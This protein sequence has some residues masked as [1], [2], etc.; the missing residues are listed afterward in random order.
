[1]ST[2]LSAALLAARLAAAAPPAGAAPSDARIRE[3]I[4]TYL[5][6]IDRPIPASR[7][8]A[9]GPAAA[10]VL[11]SIA[12]SPGEMPSDRAKAIEAL[13]V[14]DGPRAAALA[15]TLAEAPATPFSVRVSAVRSLGE[16]TPPG[17]LRG[18]LHPV[19]QNPDAR[20]RAVAAEALARRGGADGCAAVRAQVAGEPERDRGR[21]H[22]AVSLCEGK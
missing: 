12:A 11:A 16:A 20:L 8:K 10:P 21:F 18:A 5:G 1:V 3:Q 19:L 4:E 2:L 9:L 7:W 13:A 6:A 14:V 15:R 22:R 17:D